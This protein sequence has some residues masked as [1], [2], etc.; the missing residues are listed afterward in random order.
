MQRPVSM[1]TIRRISFPAFHKSRPTVPCHARE[2]PSFIIVLPQ[3][4]DILETKTLT[5][6][7]TLF[8]YTYCMNSSCNAKYIMDVSLQFYI[9]YI[10]SNWI[11]RRLRLKFSLVFPTFQSETQ[12]YRH[13]FLGRWFER[14]I[15]VINS[16]NG[17]GWQRIEVNDVQKN[18][19]LDTRQLLTYWGLLSVSFTLLSYS[20]VGDECNT[21]ADTK[22]V[23]L[24]CKFVIQ[25]LWWHLTWL[26][27]LAYLV[28]LANNHYV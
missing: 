5:P 7:W 15:Y 21:D 12:L 28:Y 11:L 26:F 16:A 1:P 20:H 18:T 6:V 24:C 13:C 9:K 22:R 23:E 14:R 25:L 17:L 19:G 10:F 2:L 3:I 8:R 4:W 27:V